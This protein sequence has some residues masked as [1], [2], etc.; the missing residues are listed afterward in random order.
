M[1][2]ST[3]CMTMIST[4]YP[5]ASRTPLL[6]IKCDLVVN[7]YQKY[8]KLVLGSKH[9]TDLLWFRS[10]LPCQTHLWPPSTLCLKT[11]ASLK[12]LHCH[13]PHLTSRPWPKVQMTL[14]FVLPNS[15]VLKCSGRFAV[16]EMFHSVVSVCGQMSDSLQLWWQTEQLI[17]FYCTSHLL[18]PHTTM[19]QF[20]SLRT[21]MSLYSAEPEIFL[22]TSLI[23][24][25]LPP[26]AGG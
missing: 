7:L 1:D 10:S 26:V 4:T 17:W 15:S 5:W 13:S 2:L 11:S 25:C 3:V 21:F 6:T 16:N 12:R 9:Q 18:L 19:S 23:S 20:F 24:K 14:F 8:Q 22:N